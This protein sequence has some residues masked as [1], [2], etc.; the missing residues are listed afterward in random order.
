MRRAYAG[1]QCH[2]D[3]AALSGLE[4]RLGALY[5]S[6]KEKTLYVMG[7]RR[8]ALWRIV[9]AIDAARG[10]GVERVGIVTRSM[11]GK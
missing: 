2:A 5:A 7:E 4:G 8:P 11:R 10:A 6:R 3:A 1:N 9:E